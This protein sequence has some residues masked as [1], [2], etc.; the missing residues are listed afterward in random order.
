MARPEPHA[1]LARRV[2]SRVA[3]I[4][5]ERGMTQ[6]TL[7]Q[8]LDIAAKNV[9]RIESGRQNLTLRTVERLA[10][11][12]GV[13]AEVFFQRESPPPLRTRARSAPSVLSRLRTAGHAVGDAT[14]RRAVG[15]V[16]VVTLRAAAG[17]FAHGSSKV[18][19][20]GWVK[21][22]MRAAASW[23]VAEVHGASMEP[24]ISDGAIGL[25]RPVVGSLPIGR[26]VL[27][28]HRDLAVDDLSGPCVLKRLSKVEHRPSGKI[29]VTLTS[30]NPR[31]PPTILSIQEP[32]ELRVIAE[33]VEVLQA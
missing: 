28:E 8:A 15:A 14:T 3:H 16:S 21:L 24:R 17:A 31:W 5:V 12:L 1:D 2:A 20:L 23:F 30:D 6:E 13:D 11:A 10:A 7:A 22:P 26:V 9:Q 33:L 29:R 25:F 32:D 18:E 27:V 19:A 4:R